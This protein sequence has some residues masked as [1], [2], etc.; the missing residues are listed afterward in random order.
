VADQP[1]AAGGFS[2]T[3]PANSITLIVIPP[4]T[5]FSNFIYLPIIMKP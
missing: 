3:F 1:L 2:A 5:P 4:G